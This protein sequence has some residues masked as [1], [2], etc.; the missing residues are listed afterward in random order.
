MLTETL[1]KTILA[2]IVI[3]EA[4]RIAGATVAFFY[5]KHGEE[6]RNSFLSVARSILA[7][8]LD[9]NP[10][11]LPYFHE[12][13]SISSD[14]LLTSTEVA[15]EMIQTAL[16]SCEKTYVIIDG[17]DECGR[18]DR[19][20][21][22]SWFQTVV[23]ALPVTEM[24]SIRCLFVGQDDEVDLDGFRNLPTIKITD[25]NRDDLKDFATV[26]HQRIENKFG[27]LQSKNY[28]ISNII[29]ARAQGKSAPKKSCPEVILE[30]F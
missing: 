18:G 15:K 9:Q 28:N 20:E 8:V 26:W 21:I 1:G 12:R 16:S 29:S 10:H 27:T 2:S 25:E 23:E 30:L 24:D 5:C 11:L 7:Q 22:T 13:A 17:L 14:V 19:R 3:D 4:R 6:T